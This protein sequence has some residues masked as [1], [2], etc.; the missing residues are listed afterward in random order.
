MHK[1][2]IHDLI[3]SSIFK[4]NVISVDRLQIFMH[5]RIQRGNRCPDPPEKSQKYRVSEQYWS[6]SLKNHKATK[7]AFKFGPLSARQRNVIKWLLIVVFAW[8]VSPF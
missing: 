6:G 1:P 7:L 4:T 2:S 8:I 5:V 3:L